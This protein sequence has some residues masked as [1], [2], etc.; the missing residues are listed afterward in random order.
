MV[1][2]A[3]MEFVK[4]FV[5]CIYEGRSYDFIKAGKNAI[6]GVLCMGIM[7]KS[8]MNKILYGDLNADITKTVS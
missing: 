4:E 3:G 8:G 5:K 6:I 1:Y 2:S 7:E